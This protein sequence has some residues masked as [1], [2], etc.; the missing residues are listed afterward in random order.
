MQDP[1]QTRDIRRAIPYMVDGGH[2]L[3]QFEKLRHGPFKLCTQMLRQLFA[4]LDPSLLSDYESVAKEV[5]KLRHLDDTS[6]IGQDDP[7]V[8]RSLLINLMTYEKRYTSTW[9][10]GLVGQVVMGDYHG[11]DILL[12]ELGLQIESKPE[13]LQLFRGRE[14]RHAT[15]AWNGRRFVVVHSVH[16][17]VKRWAFRRLGRPIPPDVSAL[18]DDLDIDQEDVVPETDPHGNRRG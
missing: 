16:E 9:H 17:A 18:D 2:R 4:D 1:K 15:T 10:R 7:F 12:R 14:L 5:A 13:S 11:G 6:T 3:Q 8:L